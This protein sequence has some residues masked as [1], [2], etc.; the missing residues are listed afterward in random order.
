MPDLIA[1]MA[2]AEQQQQNALLQ[3]ASGQRINRPS[4]DPAGSAVVVQIRDRTAQQDSF[5][6]TMSTLNGQLQTADSTL[7]SVIAAMDRA[8]TLGTQG[9][10]GTLTDAGRAD[11]AAELQGIEDQLLSLSNSS[12]EG[13]YLFAGTAR[14]EPFVRDT[15]VPSG[16]RYTGNTG[17]NSAVIGNGYQIASN[18]PGSQIFNG[19]N[20]DAFAAISGLIN[21]LQTN[22]GIDVAVGAVRTAFDYVNAQRV[23]YG[24][25]MNQI[26][27][28]QTYTKSA[29]LQLQEQ[30]NTVAAADM[31]ALA[32]QLVNA[33]NALNS[34]LAAVGKTS[35]LSLF[36]FLK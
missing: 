13:Q 26:S 31:T 1:A 34:T 30:A 4:D 11:I 8:I 18:I 24:N 19:T 3:L 6:Q 27:S 21:A 7:S 25:A 29:Q 12:Y 33:A 15:S 22:S 5:L 23:F 32:S 17:V 20:A 28:Q 2:E 14:T 36:D 9:A 10:T 35:Q 16:I